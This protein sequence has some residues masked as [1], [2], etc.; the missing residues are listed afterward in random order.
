MGTSLLQVW[1]L[2]IATVCLCVTRI[3]W[4]NDNKCF[5]IDSNSFII[6]LAWT[7]SQLYFLFYNVHSSS[8]LLLSSSLSR[9]LAL[10]Y[11]TKEKELPLDPP[12][13]IQQNMVFRCPKYFLII[14]FFSYNLLYALWWT[15]TVLWWGIN[16]R[17]SRSQLLSH[18][19]TVSVVTLLTVAWTSEFWNSWCCGSTQNQWHW[20]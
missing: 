12:D 16:N 11:S 3:L 17:S 20:H 19:R 8:Q 4:H 13:N 14:T 6:I 15:P 18:S 7:L 9:Y 1:S 10:M 5:L 2:W